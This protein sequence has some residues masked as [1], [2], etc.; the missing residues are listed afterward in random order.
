MAV[1]HSDEAARFLQSELL[2]NF[3]TETG[4]AL[5]IRWQQT[6]PEEYDLRERIYMQAQLLDAFKLYLESVI[7]NGK[8]A[9]YY[10]DQLLSGETRQP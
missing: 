7:D 3:F 10:L 9:A 2:V 8:M 4:E 6:K 5:I 1:A